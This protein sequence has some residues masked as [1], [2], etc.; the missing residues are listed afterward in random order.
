M[1]NGF[2]SFQ[3][4][5]QFDPN[6]PIKYVIIGSHNGLTPNRRHTIIQA[7]DDQLC[8]RIHALDVFD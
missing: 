3:M 8:W 6:D 2:I 4:V 5:L 1:K 7:N